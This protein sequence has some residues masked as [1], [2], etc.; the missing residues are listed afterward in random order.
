MKKKVVTII[1]AR[2]QIIKSSAINRAIREKFADQLEEIIVHTGQH[3]DEN[4]SNVFFGEMNI[5]APNYNLAIGSGSHGVQTADMLKG[6][7][8]ILIKE[9]PDALLVY[10]DTNSTLAGATAASKMGIPV[11]HVEAGLRSYNKAMPEEINRV[12]CDHLS[13]LLFSPT[14][15]GVEN[16]VK[17]GFDAEAKMPFTADNP[18]VFKCGD[19]MYDNSMYFAELAKE[20]ATV[21]K[22][23]N[24]VPGTFVL[25][26]IHRPSNTDSPERLT[27]IFEALLEVAHHGKEVVLP[28]HPRT[29]KMLATSLRPDVLEEV[30][31][32]DTLK[33][34]DPVSFFNITALEQNCL[35][36]ITD[37][38]GL[39]KE[40]F[41]FN[42]PCVVLRKETEWVEIVEN[43]NAVLA[44]ADP[45][46]IKE[47]AF[48]F[49]EGVDMEFPSF[50]GDGHAAE[51]ICK[52]IIALN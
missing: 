29:R 30:E 8:E 16:L 17:E 49:M 41:F 22:E 12:V 27:A 10:G 2:P 14:D 51:F 44:D 1:G 11:I 40:A 50:Y 36:V 34:I 48:R 6:I 31:N 52:E 23:H 35:F 24:L 39:Q 20:K 47:A 42:K 5:A 43:G 45:K 32:K 7:E 33:I 21:L 18:K 3:Y 9:N 15:S 4:M 28:L 13:T 26:T 46:K 25:C 37:S 19:V 38:G